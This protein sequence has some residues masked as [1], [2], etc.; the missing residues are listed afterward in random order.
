MRGP[1]VAAA[2]T[3]THPTSRREPTVP[4]STDPQSPRDSTRFGTWLGVAL[5]GA[6]LLA[7]WPL[8]THLWWMERTGSLLDR[9]IVAGDPADLTKA[10]ALLAMW[11]G[12]G[13]SRAPVPPPTPGSRDD[14]PAYWRTYGAIATHAPSEEAFAL[15]LAARERG[16]LDRLGRL[17]L[18]EVAAAT[19]HWEVAEQVY[20]SI[21]AVNLL[22]DRGEEAAATGDRQGAAHWYV[23]AAASLAAAA[24]RPGTSGSA[25][26]D[27]FLDPDNDR[28]TLLLR[29]GRGLLQAN[30][31]AAALPVL[32]QAE[33]ELHAHPPGVRDQQAIRFALAEALARTL[34]P[35]AEGDSPARSRAATL[36]DRAL[37]AA[38]TGWA[39]LQQA[40][41]LLLLGERKDGVFA[42]QASLA[43]DPDTPETY[44]T[45]GAVYESDGLE[46]LARDLYG[47][48]L[49]RV[50]GHPA[51]STAWAITSFRTI[52]AA[53]ALPR[54]L[55]AARTKTRDPYLFAALGD[56]HLALGDVEAARAAYREGLRRSPGAPPVRDR[57]ARFARPTG[58]TL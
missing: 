18:G 15:L 38:D 39:R 13:E 55:Q 2:W 56:C 31:P 4:N 54:L 41:V 1:R 45:L 58:A 47:R 52:S 36:M 43:L 8:L 14:T 33:S 28:A 46:P 11:P 49:E 32:E 53:E 24:D 30:A 3:A 22:V 23:A 48:G 5:L 25:N 19:G 57:L 42:L 17:W 26:P 40:K 51:L 12:P 34:P 44:L 10:G 27:D 37:E 50:P 16:R 7:S 21:D 9:Y 35:N 20:G 6:L 29:V